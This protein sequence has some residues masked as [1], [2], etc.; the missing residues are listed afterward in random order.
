M[1]KY[2]D[3]FKKELTGKTFLLN[4]RMRLFGKI[5]SPSVLYGCASWT[6]TS[7]RKRK[8]QTTPRRIL[9]IILQQG[10]RS[11][12]TAETI[13]TESSDDDSP[14]PGPNDDKVEEDEDEEEL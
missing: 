5:I 14:I 10:G 13:S 2:R 6:M 1:G 3:I 4:D 9:R 7:W 12:N 8:L 11:K